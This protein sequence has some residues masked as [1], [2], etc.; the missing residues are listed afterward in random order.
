MGRKPRVDRTPEE[1]WQSVRDDPASGSSAAKA[2]LVL[3]GFMSRLKL[4][5]PSEHEF[6]GTLGGGVEDPTRS[7]DAWG[8]RP[9]PQEQQQIPRSARDD[10]R[11]VWGRPHTE[12]QPGLTLLFRW[13]WPTF[14]M[15]PDAQ[16]TQTTLEKLRRSGVFV[17]TM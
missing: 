9:M 3:R 1:K 15:D 2:A 10:T 14:S 8:S 12:S 5:P 4:R 13:R 7:T 16:E 17:G 11:M 6:S